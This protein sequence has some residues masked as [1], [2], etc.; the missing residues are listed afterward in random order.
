M[1]TENPQLLNW[2]RS[3]LKQQIGFVVICGLME[4]ETHSDTMN[5]FD[6]KGEFLFHVVGLFLLIL[7]AAIIF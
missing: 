7:I 3:S 2:Q 1:S 6:V 4:I 5:A